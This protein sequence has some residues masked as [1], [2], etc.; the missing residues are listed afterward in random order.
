MGAEKGTLVVMVG[1]E[2]EAL[3]RARPVLAHLAS[4]VVHVGPVGAGQATK[5]CNN[6]LTAIVATGLGEVLVTGV[7]AG[8]E[9]EPLVA[10]AG[11]RLG[12]QLRA[13]QLPAGDAVHRGA[14]RRLRDGS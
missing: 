12:G 10:G 5:L 11:R 13:Q 3:E 8:V 2:A 14:Q 9:L 6:M 7:K 4:D 1:G